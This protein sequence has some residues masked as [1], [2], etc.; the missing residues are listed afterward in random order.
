MLMY[1][2]ED[3]A[4]VEYTDSNFESNKDLKKSNLESMST[5]PREEHQAILYCW[6]DYGA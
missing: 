6:F 5:I 1:I 2:K 3:Q 4:L